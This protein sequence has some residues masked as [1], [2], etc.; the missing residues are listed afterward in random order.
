MPRPSI[1]IGLG[2]TGSSIVGRVYARYS[3]LVDAKLV[4]HPEQVQFLSIDSDASSRAADPWLSQLPG[5]FVDMTEARAE[6]L[7]QRMAEKGGFF[8][9]WWNP[10]FVNIGPAI[11]GA[12]MIPAKGRLLFWGNKVQPDQKSFPYIARDLIRKATNVMRVM[13]TSSV[14]FY[15]V[16]TGSGGSGAGI[17]VDVAAAIRSLCR[18]SGLADPEIVGCLL[19]PS[20][21]RVV[22]YP[23]DIRKLDANGVSTLQA[24]DFWQG[25]DRP[26]SFQPLMD[27]PFLRIE[28]AENPFDLVYLISSTNSEGRALGSGEDIA[29]MVADGIGSEVLGGISLNVNAKKNNFVMAISSDPDL[30]GKPVSY[31]SFAASRLTFRRDSLLGYLSRRAGERLAAEV[32]A[33]ISAPELAAEARRFMERQRI[34]EKT[35]SENEPRNEVLTTLDTPRDGLLVYEPTPFVQKLKSPS[36]TPKNLLVV[37]QGLRDDQLTRLT[38]T[39]DGELGVPY[40]TQVQANRGE[41]IRR[42]TSHEREAG[43][44]L[45][46]LVGWVCAIL[47]RPTGGTGAA[48]GFLDAL[49]GEVRISRD[50]LLSELAGA[51]AAGRVGERMAAQILRDDTTLEEQAQKGADIMSPSVWP[52]SLGDRPAAI[53]S[54]RTTW[55]E[56]W[57]NAEKSVLLKDEAI[58]FYDGLLAAIEAQ[59]LIVQQLRAQLERAGRT[60]LDG[61]AAELGRFNDPHRFVLESCALEDRS[62]VD[63]AF[64]TPPPVFSEDLRF[65]FGVVL[66]ECA[67]KLADAQAAPTTGSRTG[68]TADAGR[69]ELLAAVAAGVQ[70]DLAGRLRQFG[71]ELFAERVGALTLWEALRIEAVH[72]GARTPREIIDYFNSQIAIVA[73]RASPFWNVDDAAIRTEG[74]TPKGMVSVAFNRQALDQFIATHDLDPGYNPLAAAGPASASNASS[75]SRADPDTIEIRLAQGGLPLFMLREPELLWQTFHEYRR[76]HPRTPCQADYRYRMLPETF[77]PVSEN[78]SV[79]IPFLIA[80]H[81]GVIE[82]PFVESDGRQTTSKAGYRYRRRTRLGSNRIEVLA[83]LRMGGE[84]ADRM[85]DIA[86]DVDSILSE[87]LTPDQQKD[88]YCQALGR[89][90]RATERGGG[91]KAIQQELEAEREALENHIIEWLGLSRREI[92]Q[93]LGLIGGLAVSGAGL[94]RGGR[95]AAAAARDE[96]PATRRRRATTSAATASAKEEAGGR[97]RGAAAAKAG[98]GAG[99]AAKPRRRRTTSS[100]DA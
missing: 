8:S 26:P 93:R 7:R 2:T 31:G 68:A 10:D 75:N 45:G 73:Q 60:L 4:D 9:K 47:E 80:E 95:G 84:H 42:V 43:D 53:S 6:E 63:A 65:R 78:K 62:I 64:M 50:D 97:V 46:G 54:L 49:T 88:V 58:A 98:A 74:I 35:E 72:K 79:L 25:G 96:P 20:V 67:A 86:R 29:G 16:A 55:W 34:R 92:D 69:A 41:L 94:T 87:T 59:R 77:L 71:A 82:G 51:Q 5:P 91:G 90:E 17:F 1:L 13:D 70:A 22:A 28:G 37:L 18:E 32:R 100:E 38:G 30:Q 81:L 57:L 76:L 12:G 83:A 40:K 52:P 48:L 14:A 99:G 27:S 11:D 39:V 66:A 85:E 3:S 21:V 15:L 89:L 56:P 44:Q 61:A 19:M 36:V 24:L 33:S 23:G